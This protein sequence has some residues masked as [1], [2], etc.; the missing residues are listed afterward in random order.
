[1]DIRLR[2]THASAP[3]NGIKLNATYSYGEDSQGTYIKDSKVKIYLSIE[4]IKILFKVV[5]EKTW[6]EKEMK[7]DEGWEEILDEVRVD[8]KKSK[9]FKKNKK[10][11]G[12]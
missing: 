7:K 4:M 1:M 5:G 11:K 8:I 10:H 9:K 6:D 3:R 12:E 2:Y